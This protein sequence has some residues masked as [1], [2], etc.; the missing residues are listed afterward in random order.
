MAI[1]NFWGVGLNRQAGAHWGKNLIQAIGWIWA[2]NLISP[3]EANIYEYS[4]DIKRRKESL[5]HRR[6]YNSS[7]FVRNY[8]GHDHSEQRLQDAGHRARSLEDGG[9]IHRR[10][11]PLLHQDR[12]SPLRLR[13]SFEFCPSY[14]IT[15]LP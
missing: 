8:G 6:H 14:L 7:S 2:K 15:L 10:P 12:L 9:Q 11:H 4:H 1:S 3:V 13:R 5:S